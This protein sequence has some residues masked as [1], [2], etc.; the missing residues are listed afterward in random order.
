MNIYYLKKFRKAAKEQFKIR[1]VDNKYFIMKYNYHN[2]EWESIIYSNN[3]YATNNLYIAKLTLAHERRRYI[4]DLV[5]EMREF[6]ENKKLA[7]L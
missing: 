2:D 3:D 1:F 4:L 5:K 7:K 6:K